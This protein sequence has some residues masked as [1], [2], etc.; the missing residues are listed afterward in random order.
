MSVSLQANALLSFAEDHVPGHYR[1]LTYAF[2]KNDRKTRLAEG[3]VSDN[4][5]SFTVGDREVR[6]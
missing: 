2:R 5:N 1:L 6:E 4:G 3:D